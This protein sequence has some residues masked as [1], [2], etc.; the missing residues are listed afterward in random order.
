MM[1]YVHR[2]DELGEIDLTEDEIDVMMAAAEPVE[3]VGPPWAGE[4]V[5]FEVRRSGANRYWWRLAFGDG[6]VLAT[7]E[8]YPTKEAVLEAVGAVRRSVAGADLVDQTA[9]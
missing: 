3:L 2:D 4:T 5:R 8:I 6:R 9:S 1:E 7:S